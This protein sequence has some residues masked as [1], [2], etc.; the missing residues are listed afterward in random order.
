MFTMERTFNRR[1]KA[2]GQRVTNLVDQR[3]PELKEGIRFLGAFL[4]KPLSVGAVWPSSA[5]L[6]RMLVEG[7]DLGAGRTVVELGPGTGAF[8]N[9]ILERLSHRSRFLALEI[10]PI[11]VRA[12]Q[13]RFSRA[14]VVW[15]SA[16][17]LPAYLGRSKADCIVSGLAW[18][19]MLPGT[20]NRIMDAILTSLAPGGL[21]TGFTYVHA[22]WFPTT[23][24]FRR[25]LS[26]YFRRVETLPIVWRNVPPAFVYRCWRR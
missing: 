22:C 9:L 14:Q 10:N 8:T 17:N 4:L 3:T 18:G 7:C 5:A 2:S 1:A 6:S 26:R 25:K 24:R 16:E 19:N 11:T 21:F 20:Q 15:D 12:L 13:R 23:L